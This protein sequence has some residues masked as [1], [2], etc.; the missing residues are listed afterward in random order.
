MIR[1]TLEDH[2]LHLDSGS[3][4]KVL[5]WVHS[6]P[7]ISQLFHGIWFRINWFTSINISRCRLAR[8]VISFWWQK[9]T[10]YLPLAINFWWQKKV[11]V[12]SPYQSTADD[13]KGRGYLPY[14]TTSD[15]K[16]GTGYLPYQSTSDDK[17]G[18]GYLLYQSSSDD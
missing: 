15:D 1:M 6:H 14:Q 18:R 3:F 17:K 7:M 13:K 5:V 4:D 2:V 9:G 12:I 16:K 11:Q 10:D 8:L